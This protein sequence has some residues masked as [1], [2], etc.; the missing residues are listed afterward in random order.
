ML[1]VAVLLEPDRLLELGEERGEN[2]GVP[3]QP[4]CPRRLLSEQQLRQ[5]AH[6]VGVQPTPH[7]LSGDER[8][9]RGFGAH[10]HQRLVV[11][12]EPELRDEAQAANET[13]WI[14]GEAPRPYRPEDSFPQID[15]AAERVDQLPRLQSS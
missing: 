1:P 4:Q 7:A 3:G 14:L 2:A 9:A 11:R 5:L 6:S 12:L 15:L 13:E 10:L 8:N